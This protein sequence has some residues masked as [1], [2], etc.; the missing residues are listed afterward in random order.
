[1]GAGPAAL[2]R[3]PRELT[4]VRPDSS[5]YDPRRHEQ[6]I[7]GSLRW[8]VEEAG[9]RHVPIWI[10]FDLPTAG[11]SVIK[12]KTARALGL[13]IPPMLLARADEV[14]E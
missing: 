10:V 9:R 2:V 8:T 1:M 4:P 7:P 3:A 13:E 12:L 6:P 11:P 14:V 5:A